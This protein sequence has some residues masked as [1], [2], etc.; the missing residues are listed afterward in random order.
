MTADT[1]DP[2]DYIT[3]LTID[4]KLEILD[5]MA[6]LCAFTDGE[7]NIFDKMRND[8]LDQIAEKALL[9]DVNSSKE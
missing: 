1:K 3:D 7:N 5:I 4:E 2:L 8:L 9:T 6:K